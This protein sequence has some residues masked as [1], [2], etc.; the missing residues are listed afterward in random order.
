MEGNRDTFIFVLE[1]KPFK[2]FLLD[3]LL[4]NYQVSDK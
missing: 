1:G 3:F 4:K 2:E